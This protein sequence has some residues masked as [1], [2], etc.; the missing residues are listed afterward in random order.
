M[1]L[2]RPLSAEFFGTFGLVFAG[3]AVIITDSFPGAH[4]GLLGIA[5]AHG[6]I[7]ALGIT[8]TMGV[9][10]GHLNPSVTIGFLVTK[11]IDL[12]TAGSYILAQLA[13]GTLGAVA[14]RF[15]IPNNVGRLALNGLPQINTNLELGGAIALEALMTFF[16]MSAV[17]GTIVN[18]KAPK[19]G[20]LWVGVAVLVMILVGGPL[21]GAA[22]NPA[23]AFGPAMVTQIWTGQIAY[24]LGPILGAVVAALF[25]DKVLLKEEA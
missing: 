4:S 15:L 25:W 11:R 20:G 14:T 18:P 8:A 10:G 21:T 9:S 6:L 2:V 3:T 7:L 12:R 22:M 1:R 23:R 17:M 16:L 24:W 19:H 5:L 13:G